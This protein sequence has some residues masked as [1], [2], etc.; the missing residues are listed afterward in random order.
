LFDFQQ[1]IDKARSLSN[2]FQWD[3]V[4]SEPASPTSKSDAAELD[5]LESQWAKV[6]RKFPG[7][8]PSVF[9]KCGFLNT[10]SITIPLNRFSGCK[11]VFVHLLPKKSSR[12]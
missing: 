2:H 3:L 11:K 7:K 4:V 8:H 5:R 10:R 9:M 6:I 12:E 1:I